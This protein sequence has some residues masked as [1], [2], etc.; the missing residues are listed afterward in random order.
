MPFPV[1]KNCGGATHTPSI[2]TDWVIASS[3][4]LIGIS[5]TVDC[6]TV[7]QA[8]IWCSNTLSHSRFLFISPSLPL[9]GL[10]RLRL[11]VPLVWGTSKN[12]PPPS[13]RMA[14]TQRLTLTFGSGGRGHTGIVSVYKGKDNFWVYNPLCGDL[15][16]DRE[17][18]R[19]NGAC[20]DPSGGIFWNRSEFDRI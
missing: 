3:H 19:F 13:I 10:K 4:F 2:V 14:K 6:G 12:Q 7:N 5:A 20:G 16:K 8:S 15:E 17:L 18:P 11:L 1:Q 9:H